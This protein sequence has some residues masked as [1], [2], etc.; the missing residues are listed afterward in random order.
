M[1]LYSLQ[2]VHQCYG[3]REVLHIPTLQIFNGEVLAIVGPSGAGKS[4]M[5]RLLAFL[6]APSE[7]HVELRLDPPASVT[8]DSVT[9]DVRRQ[10]AMSFQRPLLLSRSVR[11]N[12]AYGLSLRGC[13]DDVRVNTMLKQLSLQHLA[14]AHPHTLSGGETQRVS[15]ARAMLLQPRVLLLD[16]PTANLDPHNIALI[17]EFLRQQRRETGVTL[18]IVTHNIFQARRLADR[19]ALLYDGGLVEVA[20]NETFFN[21]PSDPR[22]EAFV[23][24]TLIY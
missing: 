8:Y 7:G 15:L 1:T 11:A 22:T 21:T 23:A 14:E 24:G 2:N 12:V 3:S 6:E 19:I 4:T 20:S 9:I 17:E 5:L 18:V 13:K 10:I 16:E